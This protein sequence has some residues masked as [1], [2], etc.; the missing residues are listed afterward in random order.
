MVGLRFGFGIEL[1]F[2]DVWTEPKLVSGCV[3]NVLMS[4]ISHQ[5][6]FIYIFSSVFYRQDTT[7]ANVELVACSSRKKK[8]GK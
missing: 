2:A 3:P 7:I 4:K 5:L 1:I 8:A 6:P